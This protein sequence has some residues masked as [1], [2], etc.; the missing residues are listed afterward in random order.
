MSE[1]PVT[2]QRLREG[3]P[4]IVALAS[5]LLVV[6]RPRSGARNDI[7]GS[8]PVE[9]NQTASCRIAVASTDATAIRTGARLRFQDAGGVPRAAPIWVRSFEKST[10]FGW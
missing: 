6:P 7:V 10:G 8:R 3:L 9:A 4:V 1:D 2:A 5:L